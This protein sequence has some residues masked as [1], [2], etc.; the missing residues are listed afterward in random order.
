MTSSALSILLWLSLSGSI[1]ALLLFAAGKLVRGRV[2][3]RCIYYLWLV[4]L[5][6][7]ILPIAAPFNTPAPSAVAVP[8]VDTGALTYTQQGTPS[9]P[10]NYGAG[11]SRRE[12]YPLP[13]T[14]AHT[15]ES[16]LPAEVSVDAQENEGSITADTENTGETTEAVTVNNNDNTSGAGALVDVAALVLCIWATGAGI[17]VV[18]NIFSYLKF[19][20]CIMKTA[21]P[22]SE[23]D[24]ELLKS[25]YKGRRLRLLRSDSAPTPMLIGIFRPVII[26]PDDTEDDE[27]RY[28]LMHEITHLR[29][30]DLLIKWFTELVISVHWFNPCMLLVRR[31][32]N[33]ACELS[34]DEAVVKG[35]TFAERKCYS[36]VLINCAEHGSMSSLFAATLCDGKRNLKERMT[37]I[38]KK[39]NIKTI[40]TIAIGIVL[41]LSLTGCAVAL[42]LNGGEDAESKP[43][44]PEIANGETPIDEDD[45]T[46]AAPVTV[47]D[48]PHYEEKEHPYDGLYF[49]TE[50]DEYTDAEMLDGIL[51]YPDYD[52]LAEYNIMN[53]PEKNIEIRWCGNEETTKILSV[54][55]KTV[56]FPD[57]SEG[58][59]KGCARSYTADENAGAMYVAAASE[60]VDSISVEVNFTK[61]TSER[62]YIHFIRN[63]GKWTRY[64]DKLI[65]TYERE[66]FVEPKFTYFED[67]GSY[68]RVKIDNPE[69]DK[70]TYTEYGKR[71][72]TWHELATLAAKDFYNIMGVNYDELSVTFYWFDGWNDVDVI[73]YL[74]GL[75]DE[76]VCAHDICVDRCTGQMH[77]STVGFTYSVTIDNEIH[78]LESGLSLPK[79]IPAECKDMDAKQLAL[80]Y[81]E[82]A[83]LTAYKPEIESVKVIHRTRHGEENVIDC[84]RLFTATGDCYEISFWYTNDISFPGDMNGLYMG[85]PNH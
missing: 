53:F 4:V 72:L 28:V 79:D 51:V 82:H 37:F 25:L 18:F 10:A 36:E 32:I 26:L 22:A 67:C 48:I 81:Y 17:S 45:D 71:N 19:T 74:P 57:Y 65:E 31:Q 24:K 12:T 59:L 3:R 33:H 13:Q 14:D 39:N 20:R 50:K 77:S 15:A 44:I 27:L 80:W 73:L 8:H 56:L 16:E 63:N 66:G 43:E 58:Y 29:R 61:V 46:N 85:K 23:R 62:F 68:N 1:L 54:K 47:S 52:L 38:M 7:L 2:S 70:V 60:D 49:K 6:R 35:F 42:G 5:A 40:W 30:G 34:C 83:G 78:T 75:E 69:P 76:E 84:V 55:D 21:Y 41:I 11:E 9:T 64:F